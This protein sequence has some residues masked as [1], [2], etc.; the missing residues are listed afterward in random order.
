MIL[1]AEK[2]INIEKIVL[3]TKSRYLELVF[4]DGL[5]S[6]LS[7]EF[8]RVYSPSAEVR[9]HG[10]GGENLQV[11]KRNVTINEIEQVGNYAVKFIFSDGHS[12]GIFSWS[13]LRQIS[14]KQEFMWDNYIQLLEK[15]GQSRDPVE[16]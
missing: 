9:G 16:L 3:H 8:L 15:N 6:K 7:C 14:E 12:S 2:K 4:G 5:I 13:Y 11:G 10:K 1:G